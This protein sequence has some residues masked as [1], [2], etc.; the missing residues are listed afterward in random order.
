MKRR[1]IRTTSE[2]AEMGISVMSA[3]A[4]EGYEWA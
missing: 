1:N 3:C 2:R 4:D